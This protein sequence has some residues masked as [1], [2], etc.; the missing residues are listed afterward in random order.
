MAS[1]NPW[2][3]AVT[4]TLANTNY[5]LYSLM[6]GIET[7]APERCHKLQLQADPSAT[8]SSQTRIGNADLSDTNYGVLLFATQA[9]GIESQTNSVVCSEF[10][11]RCNLAGKTVSITSHVL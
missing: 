11:L 4:L 9:F 7:N 6:Q 5:N 2:M 8:S 10:W 1:G 3:K